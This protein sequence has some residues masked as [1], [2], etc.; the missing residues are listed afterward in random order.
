MYKPARKRDGKL[1]SREEQGL[2]IRYCKSDSYIVPMSLNGKI[3]EA[4]NATIDEKF[5]KLSQKEK[6]IEFDI[7]KSGVIFDDLK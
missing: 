1:D 2:L 7:D 4:K 5:E 3:V 6:L